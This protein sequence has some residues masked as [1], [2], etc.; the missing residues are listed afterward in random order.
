[1]HSIDQVDTAAAL[2]WYAEAAEILDHKEMSSDGGQ[3]RQALH[4][5]HDVL[6]LTV[7]D[8]NLVAS[9]TADVSYPP[10]SMKSMPR[11]KES[12]ASRRTS[13]PM[14]E[15]P[16]PTRHTSHQQPARTPLIPEPVTP[17]EDKLC[18]PNLPYFVNRTASKELPVYQLKKAGGNKLLTQIRKIDGKPDVLRD[19]LEKWLG[20]KAGDAVVNPVTRHVVLKG[21][22]RQA[23]RKFLWERKF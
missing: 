14:K 2:V 23:V 10:S 3:R 9:R 18:A 15:R 22:H 17:L 19:E 1:M 4:I 13:H 12:R 21:H 11:P 5:C 20:M 8:P 16:Y 7:S 6:S